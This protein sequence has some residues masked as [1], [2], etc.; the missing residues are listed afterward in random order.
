MSLRN[1]AGSPFG[2]GWWL[3]G[4]KRLMRGPGADGTW[5]AAYDGNGSAEL[6][7]GVLGGEVVTVAGNGS[8]VWAG[9]GSPADRTPV[10]EPYGVA[11]DGEGRLWIAH[12]L[13]PSPGA[14]HAGYGALSVVRDDGTLVVVLQQDLGAPGGDPCA[15][16]LEGFQPTGLAWSAA[17]GLVVVDVSHLKTVH[18]VPDPS[19]PS[20]LACTIECLA[21]GGAWPDDLPVEGARALGAFLDPAPGIW[22][23]DDGTVLVASERKV[24][25]IRDGL[26][27]HVA[28]NG[29]AT[30]S[31]DGGPATLAGLG[32]TVHAVARDRDGNIYV[33]GAAPFDP[34]SRGVIRRIDASGTISTVLGGPGAEW[35]DDGETAAGNPSPEV[36][37]IAIRPDGGL[38]FGLWRPPP[39]GDPPAWA[40]SGAVRTIEEPGGRLRTLAGTWRRFEHYSG[41]GVPGPRSGIGRPAALAVHPAR[42]DVYWADPV[43]H[44]VRRIVSPEAPPVLVPSP[45]TTTRLNAP[46]GAGLDPG[47]EMEITRKGGVRDVFVVLP[48][49]VTIR[50]DRTESPDRRQA[51]RFEY[52]AA[53]RLAGVRDAAGRAATLDYDPGS[54]KIRS[55]MDFSGQVTELDVDGSGDLVAVRLAGHPETERTFE[56]ERGKHLLRAQT[57]GQ[58]STDYQ[59]DGFGMVR[60]VRRNG[61]PFRAID[62][63]AGK[64]LNNHL[65]GARGVPLLK[66]DAADG[67]G[68]GF[69]FTTTVADETGTTREYAYAWSAVE[70]GWRRAAGDPVF[71]LVQEIDVTGEWV[72]RRSDPAASDW[73]VRSYDS[74][75]NLVAEATIETFIFERVTSQTTWVQDPFCDRPTLRLGATGDGDSV[76]A[77]MWAYDPLSCRLLSHTRGIGTARSTRTW[78]YD[79]AGRLSEVADDNGWLLRY[80]LYDERGRPRRIERRD[81]SMTEFVRYDAADRLLE[82]RTTGADGFTRTTTRTYNALGQ[83]V[84]QCLTGGGCTTFD[85]EDSSGGGSC[86]G[87][88]T[89]R[90]ITVTDP[91]GAV[92]VREYA[93]GRLVAVTA[94][95]SGTT[96]KTWYDSGRL[97]SL[98]DAGGATTRFE[99]DWL[100]RPDRTLFRSTE[101]GAEQTLVDLQYDPQR[102]DRAFLAVTDGDGRT[103]SYAWGTKTWDHESLV[104]EHPADATGWWSHGHAVLTGRP[105]QTWRKRE[106]A[107]ILGWTVYEY[108][109]LGRTTGV[110]YAHEGRS[111]RTVSWHY[112]PNEPAAANI[113][114]LQ[115]ISDAGP[116]DPLARVSFDYHADGSV[117]T[118]T[119]HQL[120]RDY[121]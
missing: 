119:R 108:D 47:G 29:D 32:E 26:L 55:I 49:G 8:P 71:D 70:S 118:E 52:D 101:T 115:W 104:E 56:Y 54:G 96:R 75:G 107:A 78:R 112:Q 67:Q 98:V 13:S 23:A 43:A 69:P 10:V 4:H 114:R 7:R 72:W 82:E 59:Y 50:H 60:T 86:C 45:G 41:E 74:R 105:S 84:E 93:E 62:P 66:V 63:V 16:P 3:S 44:R 95:P 9:D 79:S 117:A 65:D 68:A 99:Y 48:D 5:W 22:A 88:A 25:A 40:P 33:A 37:S 106:A 121:V 1:D 17:T 27:H 19:A 94:A 30:W 100:G 46:V 110:E 14:P 87:A 21:G 36:Y 57:N 15:H 12:R 58:V 51:I 103:S 28:G 39:G 116:V 120:G 34:Y 31:G 109:G 24:W 42:G 64:Y 35:T 111:G 20:G 92:S 38:V 97:A 18:C 6:F 80:P 90:R 77:E 73:R 113:G 53:G 11:F 89:A 83:L 81:G 102:S 2:A 85:Y 76:E 91:D 61:R